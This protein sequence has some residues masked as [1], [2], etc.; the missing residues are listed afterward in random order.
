MEVDI[1]NNEQN[2]VEK[3]EIKEAQNTKCPCSTKQLLII[4]IPA[5]III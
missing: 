3:I 1:Q 2:P 4:I 5:S